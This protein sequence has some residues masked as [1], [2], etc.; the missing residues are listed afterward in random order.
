MQVTSSEGSQWAIVSI[1]YPQIKVWGNLAIL[2]LEGSGNTH[3]INMAAAQILQHL[4]TGPASL[5]NIR[6]HVATLQ[7][8]MPDDILHESLEQILLELSE[9]GIVEQI[10]T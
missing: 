7:Y 10:S 3:L 2:Y 9:L 8:Y 6:Q 1:A 5:Q 4:Q